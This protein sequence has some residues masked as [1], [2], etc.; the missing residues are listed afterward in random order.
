[1]LEVRADNEQSASSRIIGLPW[2]HA[3]LEISKQSES[4]IYTF[5]LFD[6]Y[7]ENIYSECIFHEECKICMIRVAQNTMCIVVMLGTNLVTNELNDRT[8]IYD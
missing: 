4:A 1:M 5:L 8:N 2:V 3:Y 6:I 7:T